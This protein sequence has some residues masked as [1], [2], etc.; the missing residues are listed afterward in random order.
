MENL[1]LEWDTI[2]GY[3]QGIQGFDPKVVKRYHEEGAGKVASTSS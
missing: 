3:L 2:Q 1:S